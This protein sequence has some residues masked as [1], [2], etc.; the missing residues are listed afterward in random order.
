[1]NVLTR[2]LVKEIIKGSLIALIL[3][4]TLFNL[5]TLTDE[6]K[7]LGKGNYDLKAVFY[8]LTLTSPR[9][10]YELVPSSALLGSLFVLGAMGNNRE[11]VAMRAAGLSILGILKAVFI[12]GF[13]L[14]CFSI[15]I[16]EMIAPPAE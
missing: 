12:A 16:G 13:I 15:V 8:Y 2:Y 4:L 7:D 3:L 9:V 1:M 6:L 14:V 5:F 10:L 11:L